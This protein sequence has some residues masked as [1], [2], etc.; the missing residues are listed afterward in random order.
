VWALYISNLV[1]AEALPRLLSQNAYW[2]RRFALN[3]AAI[4]RTFRYNGRV[5]TIIGVTPPEFHGAQAGTLPE[6]TLPLSMAGE[7][8]G[9]PA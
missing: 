2:M 9:D 3:P 6:I 5:F 1:P 8:L 7:I 4:G